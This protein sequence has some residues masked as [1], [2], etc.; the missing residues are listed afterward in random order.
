MKKKVALII[1]VIFVLLLL[2][3]L[4][5]YRPPISGKVIDSVSGEPI[6]NLQVERLIE[7]VVPSIETTT[8]KIER[9][10]TFTQENGIFKFGPKIILNPHFVAFGEEWVNVNSDFSDSKIKPI[11]KKY[12]MVGFSNGMGGVLRR[13][14]FNNQPYEIMISPVVDEL[15]KCQG[16][17]LCIE[18]NSFAQALKKRNVSL[19]DNVD[20]SLGTKFQRGACISTVG[21][22]KNNESI[23]D[24]DG[25]YGYLCKR[26]IRGGGKQGICGLFMAENHRELCL[27]I[28]K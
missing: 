14:K 2:K 16:E 4:L 6:P 3:L 1:V 19:C 21:V 26:Y 11:N 10:K 17:V 12:N 23:C 13:T 15:I 7:L 9:Y 18:E 27:E 5:T 8:Y 28:I 24:M 25:Y 20:K 22:I